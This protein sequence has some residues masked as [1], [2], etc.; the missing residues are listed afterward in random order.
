MI[1]NEAYLYDFLSHTV[2]LQHRSADVVDFDLGVSLSVLFTDHKPVKIKYDQLPSKQI[3][4]KVS[5]ALGCT[6]YMLQCNKSNVSVFI[7]SIWLQQNIIAV[8]ACVTVLRMQTF[9]DRHKLL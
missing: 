5:F 8:G 9:I 4:Q 6:R 3:K 7:D 1:I 2:S